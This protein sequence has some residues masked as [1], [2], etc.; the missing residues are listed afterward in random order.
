MSRP[1]A[2]IPAQEITLEFLMFF[3]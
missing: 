1:V 3:S 2:R